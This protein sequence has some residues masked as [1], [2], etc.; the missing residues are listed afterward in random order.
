MDIAIALRLDRRAAGVLDPT[1]WPRVLNRVS[2][3]LLV[4]HRGLALV[5]WRIEESKQA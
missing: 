2:S 1:L 3:S 4:L 5:Q